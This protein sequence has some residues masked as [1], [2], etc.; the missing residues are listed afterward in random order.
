MVAIILSITSVKLHLSKENGVMR[1]VVEM[2]FAS[3]TITIEGLKT[4]ASQ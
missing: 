2:L 3:P 4:A 1:L